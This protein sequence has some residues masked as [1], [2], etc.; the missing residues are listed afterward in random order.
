MNFIKENLVTILLVFLILILVFGLGVA[1]Y[2]IITEDNKDDIEIAEVSERPEISEFMQLIDDENSIL[3]EEENTNEIIS[4]TTVDEKNIQTK[5]KD[6][7][8]SKIANI[9]NNCYTSQIIRLQGYP[10]NAMATDNTI[11]VASSADGVNF[12]VTEF[13]LDNNILYTEVM[14]NDADSRITAIKVILAV[15][16]IDS[17]GQIKGYPEKMLSKA[18]GE[19]VAMNYTIEKEGVEIKQ[20]NDSGMVLKVDLNSDFSFL[21]KNQ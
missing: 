13:I 7:T 21:N 14:Y 20:L 6:I 15:A 1:I 12:F 8:L 19:E 17:V 3:N 2:K 4:S 18:L 9:F 16:L 10:I 5:D 11:T